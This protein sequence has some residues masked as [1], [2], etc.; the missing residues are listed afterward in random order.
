MG[1]ALRC[2]DRRM[3]QEFLHDSY[4][5]AVAKQQSRHRVP[6][7][8][9]CYVPLYTSVLAELGDDIGD[10]LRRKPLTGHVQKESRTRGLETPPSL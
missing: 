3:P 5:C 4:V 10:P 2:R 1:V 8:V 9:W 6:K 7:H